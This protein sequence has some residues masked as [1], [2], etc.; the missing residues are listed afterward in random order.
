M[1]GVDTANALMGVYK[2][3]HI[4]KRW[5]F[6]IF[7]YLLDVCVLNSWLLYKIHYVALKQKFRLEIAL[8]LSQCGKES[9]TGRPSTDVAVPKI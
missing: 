5:Y 4:T 1:D 2:T 3:P 7:A 9:R 8:G 6:P